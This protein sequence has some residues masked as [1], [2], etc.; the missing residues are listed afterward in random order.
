MLVPGQPRA[1]RDVEL[2]SSGLEGDRLKL[3]PVC[4]QQAVRRLGRGDEA[5]HP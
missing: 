5:N 3:I 1:G 2:G 4:S